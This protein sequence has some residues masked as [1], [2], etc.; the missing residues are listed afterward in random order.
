MRLTITLTMLL[1]A[2]A[3]GDDAVVKVFNDKGSLFVKADPAHMLTV[4]TEVKMASDAAGKKAAGTALVME[5]TGQLVRITLD[6]DAAKAG[7]K[8]AR[9]PE[10]KAAAAAAPAVAPPAVVDPKQPKLVGHLENGPLRV[11]ISNGSDTKWTE[12]QLRFNDG[13]FY[14][15]G[16]LAPHADDTVVTLKFTR[17]AGPPEPVYDHVVI[18]CD[19]GETKFIFANPH[20]PG[21]LS[22]YVEN[23][24]GGRIIVHNMSEQTWNRCDIKKPDQTHYVMEKLRAKD[25]ESIRSNNFI[26]EKTLDAAPATVLALV[27]KQGQMQIELTH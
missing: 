7:A 13:R 24:G 22:G 20:S 17:P 26:K 2:A 23:L 12:C 5:V 21:A 3:F 1:S 19:E 15:L 4:G 6:D 9:L 16:E 11:S 18:T 10:A 27:C 8:Y 25:Q 14:D